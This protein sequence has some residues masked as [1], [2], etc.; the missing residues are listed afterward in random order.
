MI[1]V[2]ESK[3]KYTATTCGVRITL[4][5]F[6]VYKVFGEKVFCK[7]LSHKYLTDVPS[8]YGTVKYFV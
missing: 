7:L 6:L 1:A 5:E 8:E 3:S 2:F 4:F